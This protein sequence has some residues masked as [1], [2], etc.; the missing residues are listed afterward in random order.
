MKHNLIKLLWRE[1][2]LCRFA[3]GPESFPPHQE[4]EETDQRL[5]R[6][7]QKN[8]QNHPEKRQ[9]KREQRR[10]DENKTQKRDEEDAA[11][12]LNQLGER[13]LL[14]DKGQ[15]LKTFLHI[16]EKQQQEIIQMAIKQFRLPEEYN[17]PLHKMIVKTS[18]I[19]NKPGTLQSEFID[20]QSGDVLCILEM[21]S[22]SGRI[23][24]ITRFTDK[25]EEHRIRPLSEY[26]KSLNQWA[27]ISDELV[28]QIKEATKIRLKLPFEVAKRPV[29]MKVATN[30]NG[31]M[32]I[33]VT[34]KE[35]NQRLAILEMDKENV[36]SVI[37]R[38]DGTIEKLK[39]Q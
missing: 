38:H 29:I 1:S 39:G 31:V 26:R 8:N 7:S 20:N 3:P 24:A 25:I 17:G 9:K 34:D 15:E 21:D 33:Q 13:S 19:K 12:I 23:Q 37:L 32:R 36:T 18:T 16:P 10:L 30:R 6:P 22:Q 28:Q 14:A 4:S 35:T 11:F 2:R 27:T 5:P